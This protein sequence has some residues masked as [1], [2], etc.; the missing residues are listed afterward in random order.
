[1][2]NTKKAFTLIELMIVV[3]I[4]WVLMSTILPRLTWA[5]ARGRD[6]ARIADISNI[7][8][9]LQT[10]Y[11]DNWMY[12]GAEEC[13]TATWDTVAAAISTYLQNNKVPQDQQVTANSYLCEKGS[14]DLRWRYYYAPIQKDGLENNAFVLC[15]DVETYQKANTDAWDLSEGWSPWVLDWDNAPWAWTDNY[16]WTVSVVWALADNASRKLTDEW[17]ANESVYCIVRP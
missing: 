8:A 12:P 9:A 10:Y 4:L 6:S 11:D 15:A 14:E 2:K 7:S 13:M 3:V 17:A 5:Q 16:N 1:M